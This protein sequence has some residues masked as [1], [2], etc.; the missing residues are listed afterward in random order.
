MCMHIDHVSSKSVFIAENYRSDCVEELRSESFKEN[1]LNHNS[2]T[3]TCNSNKRDR[4]TGICEFP[5]VRNLFSGFIKWIYNSSCH[6]TL[7]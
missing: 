5:R 7:Q 4:D 3:K 2:Q 6:I 1:D